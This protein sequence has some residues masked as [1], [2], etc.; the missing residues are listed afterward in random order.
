MFIVDLGRS[1]NPSYSPLTVNGP[2]YLFGLARY[3]ARTIADVEV[4]AFLDPGMG[5]CVVFRGDDVNDNDIE[6]F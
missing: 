3:I 2:E 1:Q 4:R 6:M 5:A